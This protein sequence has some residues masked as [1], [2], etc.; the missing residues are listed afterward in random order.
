MAVGRRCSEAMALQLSGAGFQGFEKQLQLL[1][2]ELRARGFV[3]TK[4]S[5]NHNN[6]DPKYIVT[7]AHKMSQSDLIDILRR[8][9]QIYRVCISSSAVSPLFFVNGYLS[10]GPNS[11]A[12]M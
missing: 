10:I 7:H 11:E 3:E 5:R 4:D 2:S 6:S 12:C 8:Q 1:V 9:I